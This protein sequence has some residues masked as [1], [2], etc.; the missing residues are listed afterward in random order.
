MMFAAL[1]VVFM[2]IYMQG[3]VSPADVLRAN[4]FGLIWLALTFWYFY[5]YEA[6]V[7]YYEQLE[8]GTLTTEAT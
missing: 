5:R 6:V 4:M 1:G 7:E 3:G 2:L 8:W